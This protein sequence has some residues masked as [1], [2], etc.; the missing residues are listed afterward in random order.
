MDEFERLVDAVSLGRADGVGPATARR[1]MRHFGSA[2]DVRKASV[3]E[4]KS[5]GVHERVIAA[6]R[7]RAH[8]AQCKYDVERALELGARIVTLGDRDYPRRLNECHDGPVALYTLGN[9]DLNPPRAVA[10]V[11]TRQ[12]S[13]YG[14]E[15]TERI[16]AELKPFGVT[17]ISGLAYGVDI[18]AHRA[19]LKHGL[20]TLAC[21]AHGLHRIYPSEHFREAK[22]MLTQGGGWVSEFPPGIQPVRTNFP[23]RNRIIAGLADATVVIESGEKG[24]SMI[25][26][27]LAGSYHREVF[28]VP[29]MVTSRQSSGCNTL[30]RRL[31]AALLTDGGQIAREL[32]WES[33]PGVPRQMTLLHDLTDEERCIV[34][35]LS[36]NPTRHIDLLLSDLEADRYSATA[37]PVA[38]FNLEM[39]GIIRQLPG[40]RY[41]LIT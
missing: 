15:M 25:T 41:S 18:H 34:D 21:L 36:V 22:E 30:I 33:T 4:L 17:I 7:D 9:G 29:G 37:L 32:G 31:E 16:V 1:L 3:R 13:A 5:L 38:L 39:N 24:G 19:A 20:P 11:G 14:K 26:A 28:A 10:I 35:A 12:V 23:E 40:K 27:R 8:H 6:L 2:S